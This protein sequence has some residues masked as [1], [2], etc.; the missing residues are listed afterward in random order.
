VADW[1]WLESTRRLQ[2]ESF[3]VVY[4]IEG[5]QLADYVVWNHTALVSEATELLNEFGWKPWASPRGWVNRQLALKEAVD[6]AHFLANIMCAIDVTDDEWEA[7]YRSKQGVNATR[8]R[9]GYDGI[10]GKCPGCKR[11]Y[12]DDIHCKPG[13]LQKSA[14]GVVCIKV[15]AQCSEQTCPGCGTDYADTVDCYTANDPDNVSRKIYCGKLRENI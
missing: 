3:G 12:D 7:A 15:G 11:A 6:V 1:K 10:S 14:T 8:Q 9:E 13:Y 5:E 2:E 4:P